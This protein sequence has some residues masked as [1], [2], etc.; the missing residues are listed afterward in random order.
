MS[1]FSG[2]V[3]QVVQGPQVQD[4]QQGDAAAARREFLR[5]HTHVHTR[6]HARTHTPHTRT[7]TCAHTQTPHTHTRDTQAHTHTHVR[8]TL[9]RTRMNAH[10][11]THR[12]TDRQT[13]RHT[14]THTHTHTEYPFRRFCSVQGSGTEN[15]HDPSNEIETTS[16]FATSDTTQTLLVSCCLESMTR[17]QW[18]SRTQ[19]AQSTVSQVLLTCIETQ[20]TTLTQF[21][22]LGPRARARVCVC[23]CVCVC[24]RVVYARIHPL[25]PYRGT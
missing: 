6:T 5:T 13:D 10:K 14:H 2:A 1:L 24:V 25:I 20:R 9:A 8:C 19:C 16:S 22:A 4:A 17:V 21:Q 3:V 15:R 7:H 23:V 11:H 12:Q 18:L